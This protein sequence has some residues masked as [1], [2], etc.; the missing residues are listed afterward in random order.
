MWPNFWQ[1]QQVTFWRFGAAELEGS[2]VDAMA[3]V[4][5]PEETYAR[6]GSKN[7]RFLRVTGG[8]ND[9][10][11]ALLASNTRPTPNNSSRDLTG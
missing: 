8:T 1:L 6:S 10:T 7:F 5:G 3:A 2:S 4:L 11:D 9:S